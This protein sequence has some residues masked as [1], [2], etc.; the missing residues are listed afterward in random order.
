[1]QSSKRAIYRPSVWNLSATVVGYSAIMIGAFI[2]LLP[3][4]YMMI[5]ATHTNTDILSVPPPSWFGTHLFANISDLVERRPGFW[6][7]MGLS[8]WIATATTVLNL[9]FC[10]LAGYAFSMYE[11]KHKE[12]FFTAILATMLLPGFVGMIPTILLMSA[13][14]WMNTTRALI[15]PGACGALGIFMMRQ[16]ITSAI[17]RELIEAARMD[18][19]GE[20]GIYWR[21]VLPLLGPAMGTLGLIT[22]I[23]SYNN[24]VGALLV[25]RDQDYF[26]VPL[27]LRSL[28]GT[29]GIAAGA[30]SAGAAITVMPLLIIFAIYSRRLI[31]GLTA[32]AVKG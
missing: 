13:I 21:V 6:K 23:G 16:Y 7:S 1:M 11:F 8:L 19:C 12:K 5:Y 30:I 24:F 22:F 10:S 17:P 3:F 18:A 4:Y 20:F 15:V 28:Q 32:G 25:M 14:D 26:T 27:V 9:F 31:E 2:M 29:S